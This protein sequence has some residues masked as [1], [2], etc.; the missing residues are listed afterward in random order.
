MLGLEDRAL[1]A[2]G[3]RGES[4]NSAHQHQHNIAKPSVKAAKGSFRGTGSC[5]QG[6]LGTV[7][8]LGWVVKW[9]VGLVVTA[10]RR[11]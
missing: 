1:A 5:G 6:H 10:S 7:D 8:W 3:N 2:L 4:Q 9:L 11:S